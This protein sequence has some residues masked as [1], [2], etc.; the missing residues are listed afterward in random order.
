MNY[1]I[2]VETKHFVGGAIVKDG[3]IVECAP[4]LF[5]HVVRCGRK[6]RQ[7]VI[8]CRERG[9]SVMWMEDP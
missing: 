9:W 1:I 3:V 7:F 5:K 6:A 8:Q 4:I 2:R